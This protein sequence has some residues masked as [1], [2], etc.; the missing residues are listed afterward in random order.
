MLT[1]KE[2]CLRNLDNYRQV[3]NS[4]TQIVTFARRR[5]LT[6][7]S[8]WSSIEK[9]QKAN[10]NEPTNQWTVFIVK[11]LWLVVIRAIT[12]CWLIISLV[13]EDCFCN[14]HIQSMSFRILFFKKCTQ[15]FGAERGKKKASSTNERHE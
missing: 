2:K 1:M 11:E 9:T 12:M 7:N 13:S 14:L 3:I 5:K 4:C 6:S 8:V 10:K 15:A